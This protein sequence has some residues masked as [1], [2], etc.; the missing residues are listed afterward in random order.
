MAT[1]GNTLATAYI[2]LIPS[3]EGAEGTIKQQLGAETDG[4][5][6]A[7]G[8]SLASRIKKAILAAGIGKAVVSTIKTAIG[9]GA[10]LEQSIGGIETLFKDS[11]DTM[12]AYAKEAYMTAGLS[13]NEYME[14]A[15][16]FA[17]GL[18]ASTGGNT[19]EAAE[20]ANMALIDMSDNANKMGSDMESL[21]NAYQGFAKQNYTMLDNLKLGYGGTKEEMA[22]LLED[23]EKLSGVH[24]DIDNLADVYNAIHVI[25]ESLDIT[26][27]T[28]KEAAETFSGSFA[29]MKAAAQNLMGYM[30]N[31]NLWMD[32]LPAVQQLVEAAGTFLFDNAIPMLS[33]F[34]LFIPTALSYAID[35]IVERIRGAG[36]EG[37]KEFLNDFIINTETLLFSVGELV[38]TVA[39][40]IWEHRGEFL[41]VGK[42]C[43]QSFVDG[44]AQNI[45]LPD[46]VYQK[47][48]GML[49]GAIKAFGFLKLGSM[50][51]KTIT[52]IIDMFGESG[53]IGKILKPLGAAFTSAGGG[54]AGLKAALGTVI[55]PIGII[56]AAVA[57]L[58]GAFTHLWTT[59]EDFRDSMTEIW[60]NISKTVSRFCSGIVDRINALGYEFG[61]ITEVISALWQELCD[62]LA[63]I[64]EGVWKQVEVILTGALDAI[65]GIVDI[66]IALFQG[67]WDLFWEGIQEVWDACW[68]F[69]LD[70]VQNVIDT[71]LN[72]VSEF[73]SWFGIEWQPNLDEINEAWRQVWAKVAEF[74]DST[75]G[76]IE[77]ICGA[78]IDLFNGDWDGFCS[79]ISEAWSNAWTG[80]KN[81]ASETWENLKKLWSPVGQWFQRKWNELWTGISDFFSEIWRKITTKCSEFWNGI[82]TKADEIWHSF[83]DPVTEAWENVKATVWTGIRLVGSVFDAAWKIITLPF[84]FI[85]ENCKEV[86]FEVWDN[87]KTF[88]S[89]TWEAIKTKA[90]EIFTP[91][92]DLLSDTWTAISDTATEAWNNITAFFAE[93]WEAIK[94]KAEEIFTPIRDFI[95]ETWTAV[96]TKATEIWTAITGFFTDTWNGIKSKADEAFTSTRDT[97]T[98]AFQSVK[99]KTT[100]IWDNIKGFC[101]DTWNSIKTTASNVF[102]G[103]KDAITAPIEKAKEIIRNIVDTI[104][105]FFEGMNIQLPHIKLPHF[106]VNP[107]GW[108][109]GDLLHGSIPSLGIEWYKN[110]GIMTEPTVF[111]RRGDNLMVGGEAGAEAVLPLSDFY[112]HLDKSIQGG[113]QISAAETDRLIGK[114]EEV[115]SRLEA[116]FDIK[117]DGRSVAKSVDKHMQRLAVAR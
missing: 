74:V 60:N 46:E 45:A 22:R 7:I 101:S 24:Y 54:F 3:F 63:P 12:T 111:G 35:M 40:W 69:I 23:A 52:P 89:E 71:I 59:N 25:Q 68:Y 47:L 86:V 91:I 87:I 9:E 98:G 1:T 92:R 75:I 64:F 115:A 105:G 53:I 34:V 113:Q 6:E 94:A 37:V 42:A 44:I 5:G 26:G 78:F 48:P 21:Q 41:E 110:G 55:G 81:F 70:T 88:V 96:Q 85:W 84:A 79:K 104:K 10:A 100:E 80:I 19:A 99:D 29:A 107:P 62:F 108:D 57:A 76:F 4:A 65:T 90:E 106:S 77:D 13:A 93:S 58:A 61:D 30:T 83:A 97:V 116:A 11:A 114:L 73:L 117:L 72:C 102:E 14:Q 36:M 20:V 2:Q 16:S 43:I 32:V 31:K 56:G 33:N 27:T 109:I 28:S 67:D 15:T 8:E 39:A 66:F 17:A 50:I 49:E 95:V 112:R 82:K 38:A 51:S 18:I 103:I